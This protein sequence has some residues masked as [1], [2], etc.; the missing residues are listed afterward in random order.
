MELD[1][2]DLHREDPLA[3][4]EPPN[5]K[6]EVTLATLDLRWLVAAIFAFAILANLVVPICI[7]GLE[8]SLSTWNSTIYEF[9]WSEWIGGMAYGLKLG[10]LLMI[11]VFLGLGH[12]HWAKR[13]LIVSFGT[14]TL[15]SAHI[16]G[17]RW[18]GWAPPLFIAVMCYLVSFSVTL[19]AGVFLGL[20]AKWN[21]WILD[22]QSLV[23]SANQVN[24]QFDTRL[25]F[26]IM[27]AVAICI[28]LLKSTLSIT[29]AG[30]PIVFDIIRMAL[31]SVWLSVTLCSLMVVQKIA[32]L[33][34]NAK[35]SMV[36]FGIL[37]ITGPVLFQWVAMNVLPFRPSV[38]KILMSYWISF[39]V[40]GSTS[41]V[42]VLLRW[43]GYRLRKES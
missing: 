23:T 38:G 17:Y 26:G 25:L 28:P 43:M 15:A 29:Q 21:R 35:K 18:A 40:V 36:A 11:G 22:R 24:H 4:D 32:F 10:E 33:V 14:L 3:I 30:I 16:A 31:W 7:E 27:I 41:F 34:P 5:A 8:R 2:V 39:G 20:I 37:I 42:F 6:P 13:L 9:R 1:N 19:V 12:Y